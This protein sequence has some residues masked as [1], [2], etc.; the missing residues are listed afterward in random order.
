[1]RYRSVARRTFFY[2]FHVAMAATL[3]D[4][5]KFG[6][7]PEGLLKSEFYGLTYEVVGLKKGDVIHNSECMEHNWRDA[8]GAGRARSHNCKFIRNL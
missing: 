5:G 8:C 1:M 4:G 2:E 7:D 6:K 3:I